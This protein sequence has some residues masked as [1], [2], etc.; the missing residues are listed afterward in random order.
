MEANPRPTSLFFLPSIFFFFFFFFFLVDVYIKKKL[1][2]EW[3]KICM[4]D[5]YG[6]PL[7]GGASINELFSI[8]SFLMESGEWSTSLFKIPHSQQWY[9]NLAR[10]RPT[11]SRFLHNNGENILNLARGRPTYSRFTIHITTNKR[12]NTHPHGI[13]FFFRTKAILGG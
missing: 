11:Y 7:H 1:K 9:W 13:T 5:M 4:V 12:K 3:W 10:G 6:L 8:H 2:Y